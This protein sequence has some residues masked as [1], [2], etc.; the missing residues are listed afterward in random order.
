MKGLSAS[1]QAVAKVKG[2]YT[3]LQLATVPEF[4]VVIA[5][6]KTGKAEQVEVKGGNA[7]RLIGHKIGDIIDGSILGKP[8]LKLRITGGSGKAGE[9]MLPFVPGGVKKYILLSRPPGFHPREKG[10]RRRKFVRGSVITDEIVQI[11]T[12]IVEGV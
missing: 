4:K 7:A 3:L 2:F 6:P 5:D 1:N 10:E 11:N 9:P 12:V 8:G